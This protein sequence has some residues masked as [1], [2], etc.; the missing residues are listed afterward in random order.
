MADQKLVTVLVTDLPRLRFAVTGATLTISLAPPE[1]AAPD[2]SPSPTAASGFDPAAARAAMGAAAPSA[3]TSAKPSASGFDPAAALA[4]MAAAPAPR[5]PSFD[6]PAAPAA[7]PAPAPK[8]AEPESDAPPVETLSGAASAPEVPQWREGMDPWVPDDDVKAT[9][10]T[11]ARRWGWGRPLLTLLLGK[12]GALRLSQVPAAAR[13]EFIENLVV[14]TKVFDDAR[15]HTS[16]MRAAALDMT[17]RLGAK[18]YAMLVDRVMRDAAS[19]RTLGQLSEAEVKPVFSALYA[20]FAL[21]TIYPMSHG[22]GE[23]Y[24]TAWDELVALKKESQHA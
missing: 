9:G 4:A 12:Y 22:F 7:A 17:T 15:A 20:A 21:A 1:A 8:P 18:G 3:T 24:L 11:L 23:R 14:L 19:G 6:K 10:A 16:D 2:A 13:R 5:D